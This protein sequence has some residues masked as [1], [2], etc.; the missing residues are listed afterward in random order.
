MALVRADPLLALGQV[1]GAVA[2][3]DVA[4]QPHQALQRALDVVRVLF[5]LDTAV[6]FLQVDA[7]SALSLACSPP[8]A[9]ASTTAPIGAFGDALNQA[10]PVYRLTSASNPIVPHTL[11]GAMALLPWRSGTLRGATVLV[12]HSGLAFSASERQSMESMADFLQLGSW[13][14]YTFQSME[15]ERGRFDAIVDSV[16]HAMVYV[17]ALGVESWINDRAAALLGLH[18][19]AVEPATL[20]SAMAALWS[21]AQTPPDIGAQLARQL[22]SP[23]AT[24]SDLVVTFAHNAEQVFSV[25]STP[26]ASGS[27]QGR[28]WIFTDISVQHHAQSKVEKQNLDLQVAKAAAEQANAAKDVFL[29]TMSHEIRTPMTGLLGMLELLSLS[30]LSREQ[31][32]TLAVAHDSGLALGRIIDDILDHAK[33]A[34]G[35]LAITP[36][37][38]SLVQLLQRNVNTYMA[39]ASRKG[40]TLRQMVDPRIS[41]ALMADPLRLLQVLSNLVSNAIKFTQE[42]Y[43][44]VRAE[45]VSRVADLET[46]RLL[47][48]DTGIGMGPEVQARVFQPFEQA[49][50]DTERLYG[51]TGLGLA[52]SRRLAQMMGSDVVIESAPGMG[53]TMSATLTLPITQSVRPQPVSLV[54]VA[55]L[56][57]AAAQLS[58]LSTDVKVGQ[59]AAAPQGPWV[60]A[61]DDNPTNRLLIERQLIA[62]GMRVR[63]AADGQEAL[64][65]WRTGAFALVVTDCNMPHMDGYALT[66][67]LRAGE[68]EVGQQRTPILGWT[69]NALPDTLRNCQGAGMDDVLTKPSELSVLRAT[70][71]KWLPDLSAQANVPVASPVDASVIDLKLLRQAYAD[72]PEALRDM[73]PSIRQALLKQIPEVNQAIQSGDLEAIQ[74]ASHKIKGAASMI[75]AQALQAVCARMEDTT[76]RGDASGLPELKKLFALEAQRVMDALQALE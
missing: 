31:S 58:T 25:S 72:D 53:T 61:V 22:S 68:A 12:R 43:V 2:T 75:G 67:A 59:K 17:D 71:A 45:F 30:K 13:L 39:V 8:H 49:G 35:K 14:T 40:L 33:I 34:A 44:E 15:H 24:I 16:P 70:L 6:A 46:V 9:L 29:A 38:V 28:L 51:G 20:A 21:R 56:W 60:L 73:L 42:G 10:Q 36:E 64:A 18:T 23:Q 62:L 3:A 37:P 63:T 55:P 11:R 47:V 32:E 76:G 19:G 65:L 57:Q 4:A 74:R 50:I 69:A 7:V 1:A 52:I 26:T 48:K 27:T 54:P 5:Q 41:P 66:R